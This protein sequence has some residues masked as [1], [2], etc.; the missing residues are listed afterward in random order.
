[1]YLWILFY[2]KNL[3]EKLYKTWLK[4]LKA[5]VKKHTQKIAKLESKLI[6]LELKKR[7]EETTL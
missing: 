2:M 4:L 6:Q 1:M 3:E 7:D 5:S